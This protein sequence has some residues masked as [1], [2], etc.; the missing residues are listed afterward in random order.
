VTRDVAKGWLV[1]VVGPS[2]AGKDTLI[3]AARHRLAADPRFVFVRRVVTRPSNAFE[4]HDTL[5]AEQFAAAAAAGDFA[6][7]WHAHGLSYGLRR[8]ID[9][10]IAAGHI[11]VCNVSRG[12]VAA[13]REKHRQVRVVHVGA[14]PGVLAARIAS[15]GRDTAGSRSDSLRSEL[16]LA[17]CDVAIDNS[18]VLETAV[19]S[20]IQA[21]MAIGAPV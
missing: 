19:E 13:A 20:F 16:A 12:I 6:L 4:D 14:S 11:V 21:L 9:D 18:G 8:G 15:R 3:S 2:G 1:L 7:H 10:H 5:T 17:I